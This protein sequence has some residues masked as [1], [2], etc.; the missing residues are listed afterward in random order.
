MELFIYTVIFII[1]AFFGSFFTLAV[2]RI[3]L[4]LD[5]THE[6][7]FCPNC[8]TKLKIIDLIPIFSYLF[9][10][11]KCRYC[12]QKIKIR[13]LLLEVLS[14]LVFLLFAISL[15]IN[16]MNLQAN[17]I[18]TFCFYIVYIACL[19]II[20]GIDKERN[21]IQKSV[22]V[23][24]TFLTLA[25][26][27]YVCIVKNVVIYTYIIGLI[28]IAILV[29]IDTFYL[30]RNLTSNYTISILALSISMIVFSGTEVFYYSVALSLIMIAISLCVTKIKNN[31]KNKSVIDTKEKELDIPIGFFL[32]VSNIFL[33]IV[34]NLLIYT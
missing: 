1:G 6:H 2:Y 23:F 19:F 5:I 34:S 7:S 15:R 30:K 3:P 17:T 12:G 29:M 14:G 11:G 26:M 25:F 10:G 16:F 20:A 21:N 31:K 32:S 28:S 9:L 33:L 18:I 24:M 22:L 4:G 13:Y 27:V 8:N